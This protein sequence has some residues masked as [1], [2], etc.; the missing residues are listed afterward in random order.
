MVTS[1]LSEGKIALA[2]FCRKSTELCEGDF[3]FVQLASDHVSGQLASPDH[4]SSDQV[5]KPVIS[6]QNSPPRAGC[7]LID[8]LTAS[9]WWADRFDNRRRLSE[10]SE[11]PFNGL[12]DGRMQVVRACDHLKAGALERT[13]VRS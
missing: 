10:P 5:D 4:Q 11:S 13:F 8:K 12:S 6:T 7:E 1:K 3:A 2:Q 9:P